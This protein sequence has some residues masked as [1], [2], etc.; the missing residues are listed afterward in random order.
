MFLKDRWFLGGRWFT[1]VEI[2]DCTEC[3]FGS[4]TVCPL[5]DKEVYDDEINIEE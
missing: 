5:E 4:S 3:T 2:T 1:Y